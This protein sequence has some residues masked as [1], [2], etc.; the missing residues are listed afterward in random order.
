MRNNIAFK[1]VIIPATTP[2]IWLY[3]YLTIPIF[4]SYGPGKPPRT[5]PRAAPQ[6][7]YRLGLWKLGL[8][9]ATWGLELGL[10]KLGLWKLGLSLPRPHLPTLPWHGTRGWR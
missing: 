4:L 6:G 8:C 1:Y 2:N 5:Q 7:G 3:K 10:W 9:L